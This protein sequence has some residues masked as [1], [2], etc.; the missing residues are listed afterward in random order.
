MFGFKS[1][2]TGRWLGQTL[3]GYLRIAGGKFGSNHEWQ[4]RA[5]L[6][7]CTKCIDIQYSRIAS[8]ALACRAASGDFS[9]VGVLPVA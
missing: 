1:S 7:W 6:L 3:L 2:V 9:H 4:V 8:S 5:V